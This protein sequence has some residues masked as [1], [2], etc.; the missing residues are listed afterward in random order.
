MPRFDCFNMAT[1]VYI[2]REREREL[3]L[4]IIIN[5]PP[6]PPNSP[7]QDYDYSRAGFLGIDDFIRMYHSLLYVKS[8]S[9]SQLTATH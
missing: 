9:E 4:N 6:L 2:E 1:Q 3:T 8:V 5:P 7:A